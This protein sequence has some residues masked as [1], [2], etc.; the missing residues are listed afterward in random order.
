MGNVL[1]KYDPYYILA[2]HGVKDPEDVRLLSENIFF[3]P[4]WY[5][6]DLGVYVEEDIYNDAIAAL[7]ER[8]HLK[9][10]E[11]LDSWYESMPPIEGMAK[12]VYKLKDQGLN[13]YLLSNAGKSKDIYWGSVPAN[14]CFDGTVVSAFEGCVKPDIRIYNILLERYDLKAQES[15]FIDD[16]KANVDGAKAAGIAGYLFDEDVEALS[17]FIFDNIG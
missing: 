7:P 17:R 15:I 8:L 1:I 11:I 4:G 9:A 6:M 10:K 2:E 3:S 14:E 12:L 13:I 16:A 5:K